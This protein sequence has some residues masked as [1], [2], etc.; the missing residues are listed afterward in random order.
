MNLEV[1]FMQIYKGPTPLQMPHL[2]LKALGF[3]IWREGL[4]TLRFPWG[5]TQNDFLRDFD[6]GGSE[7][8]QIVIEFV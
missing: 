6:L 8:K 3:L 1:S 7:I 5:Y 2:L 4:A